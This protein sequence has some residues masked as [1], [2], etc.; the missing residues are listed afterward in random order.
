MP[1][2]AVFGPYKGWVH[3]NK[4]WVGLLVKRG[5]LSLPPEIWFHKIG[6]SGGMLA[7]FAL[8]FL[9]KGAHSARTKVNMTVKGR[10]PKAWG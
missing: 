5:L 6:V 3:F 8:V 2:V 7:V 9:S 4:V 10:F 1:I